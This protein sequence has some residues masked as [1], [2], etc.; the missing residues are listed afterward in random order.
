MVPLSW[1]RSS[2]IILRLNTSNNYFSLISE[3]IDIYFISQRERKREKETPNVWLL[4]KCP[5]TQGG[6][7][8]DQGLE[9]SWISHTNGKNP[10]TWITTSYHL[11]HT[12]AECRSW[13]QRL[14]FNPD[15]L[16]WDAAAEAEEVK[17][18]SS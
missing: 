1:H 8:Q 16:T 15:T 4:P 17:S 2:H 5:P 13:K 3:V 9:L 10:N 12:E 11:G 18:L 14:N 7:S 6:I